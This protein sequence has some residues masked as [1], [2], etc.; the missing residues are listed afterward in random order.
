[1]ISIY[2]RHNT[3]RESRPPNADLNRR[4]WRQQVQ[5]FQFVAN[6]TPTL[7]IAAEPDR[8]FQLVCV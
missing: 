6:H 4:V 8:T 5:Q 3:Q 1:M 2:K 7:T